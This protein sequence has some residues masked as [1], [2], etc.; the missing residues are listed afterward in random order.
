MNKKLYKLALSIFIV[1]SLVLAPFQGITVAAAKK[2]LATSVT[3][4]NPSYST[5][6]I[7]KGSSK[8]LTASIAPTKV[9]NTKLKWKSSDTS[10]VTV[11]SKGVIKGIKNGTAKVTAATTD[12]SD[13]QTSIT[14]TVGTPV[15]K[16]TA[17][18]TK[19]TLNEGKTST[20]KTTITP[21]KA[22]NKEVVYTTSNKKVAT[23]TKSGK[24][25][26]V[27]SGQATITIAA[28]DGSGKTAKVKVVVEGKKVIKTLTDADVVNGI[29]SLTNVTYDKLTIDSSVG[30]AVIN[31]NK[32]VI[33]DALEMGANAKYV[34]KAKDS[35]INKVVALEEKENIIAAFSNEEVV[36]E[37]P[38]FIAEKGTLVV[39]IDARGNVSV[40]QE[41]KAT[42]GTITVNRKSDGN[43]DLNIEGFNGNLVVN[44]TSNANIAISTKSCNIGEATI[45]GTSSGQKLTLT[46][47]STQG[48]SSNIGKI[49]I[50][51]NAK[52]NIDVK[53]TEL[54]IAKTVTNASV[55]V[56]KPIETVT[57]EGE[58]TKLSINSNVN[59]VISVG[60][61]LDIKVSAGSTI[62]S[63]EAS[64]D[65]SKI[66]VAL[67]ST[68]ENVV[69]KGNN[70]EIKGNGKVNEVKVEGNDTKVNTQNTLV[71][72]SENATGTTANGESVSGGA[73]I[74][75]APTPV[76]PTVP[77]TPTGAPIVPTG[78]PTGTPTIAPTSTPTGT[79]TGTPTIAPT[80]TP[81]ATPTPPIPGTGE[82]IEISN[83]GDIWVSNDIEFKADH[84][85]ISWSVY[86]NVN[87]TRGY[88]TIDS[89]TGKL[90]GF[91]AGTVRV[92]ATSLSNEKVYGAVDVTILEKKFVRYEPLDPVI[93]DSDQSIS[94]INELQASG[95]LPT[96][97]S[98][99][100]ETGIDNETEKITIDLNN[101]WSGTITGGETGQKWVSTY[102]SIPN[103]YEHPSELYAKVVVDIKVAQSSEIKEVTGYK[104]LNPII[105][106]EDQN[107]ITINQ[108]YNKYRDQIE[109]QVEAGEENLSIKNFSYYSETG[110]QF[111]GAVPGTYDIDLYVPLPTNY[112]HVN[113]RL[114][115]RDVWLYNQTYIAIPLEVVVE[116]VQTPM[117]IVQPIIPDATQPKFTSTKIANIE[118]VTLTDVPKTFNFGEVIDFSEYLS[119]VTDTNLESD[120]RVIWSFD[121]YT[122]MDNIEPVGGKVI[123]KYTGAHTITARSVVDSTK[124]VTINIEVVNSKNIVEFSPLAPIN[125]GEDLHINNFKS[126]FKQLK[127]QL[128]T[129]VNGKDN[130]GENVSLPINGWRFKE[131]TGAY[132]TIDV[133][134][135]RDYGYG[136]SELPTLTINFDVPQSDDRIKVISAESDGTS[137]E[138]IED[139]YATSEWPLIRALHGTG[140]GNSYINFSATLEDGTTKVLRGKISGSYIVSLNSPQSLYNG[141]A[142]EY[143]LNIL[144]EL[145]DGYYSDRTGFGY[146]F[147]INH[148]L[149][150]RVDQTNKYEGVWV[151][152][153]PKLNYKVGETLDLSELL[154]SVQD[155]YQTD[156][157]MY[158]IKYDE[159]TNYGLELRVGYQYGASIST[160]V[161]L[162]LDLNNQY[163]YILNPKNSQYSFFGPLTV[164]E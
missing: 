148:K 100:Y 111:N 140:P 33:K 9:S 58:S 19:V 105:I 101:Q 124:S 142:G 40:K 137:Y 120:K 62:K 66:E 117:E 152:N 20:I 122:N 6:T 121:K 49:N 56:E 70:A 57:N 150:I 50:E 160:E 151:V 64:G 59:N 107:I 4:T 98:L 22:T 88:A 110:S 97:I 83:P 75:A 90:R 106:K 81:I 29:I 136:Y 61:S 5:Y 118:S 28:K 26:A 44:T 108:F 130:N 157:T 67:G 48:N 164:T 18:T 46:D 73:T 77:T 93:I 37:T 113:D 135:N 99:I 125:V 14:V 134:F 94:D 115:E 138:L 25:T 116:A 11:S 53:A 69:S 126:M 131:I 87:E 65:S 82:K 153:Q 60:D 127:H 155:I 34:V 103:G 45:G 163:I 144:V 1:V 159:F 31:L 91:S 52:V 123:M 96:Q 145:P 161:P 92:V 149:K 17:K 38:T 147:T 55:T 47:N 15:T 76:P 114:Y 133:G 74:T 12:G 21:S 30:D 7:A 39:T 158:F 84:D 32:V 89:T 8:K 27:S 119:V 86:N 23:V 43:I 129:V 42:I 10:I 139:K 146:D 36:L 85:N 35:D 109:I 162:T 54:T 154:V 24:I 112:V 80:G 71:S 72:V 128:P 51:T 132:M 104:P 102:I 95:K 79:P 2:V 68:I 13:K 143:E 41:G 141:K 78:T 63:I 3:I 156:S 16:I